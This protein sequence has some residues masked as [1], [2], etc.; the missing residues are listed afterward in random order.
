M[1]GDP[2]L[3]PSVVLA[4]VITYRTPESIQNN[5]PWLLGLI[6]WRGVSVPVVS[7]EEFCGHSNQSTLLGT[8][9]AILN[10]ITGIPQV[11]F[12]GLRI[13]GIPRL[14]LVRED[15][16]TL[17]NSEEFSQDHTM[18]VTVELAEQPA[19]IPD[20]AAL[21]S[22]LSSY[23]NYPALKGEACESKP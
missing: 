4:E 16:L 21:E 22:L 9:I 1:M 13:Q 3:L 12:L 2:L 11:P 17:R 15:E 6:E 10:T 5:P 19:I 7:F 18:Y 14:V 8:R 20:L 23:I